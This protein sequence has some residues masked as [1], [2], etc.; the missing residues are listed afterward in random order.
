[1]AP[2]DKASG[3][4]EGVAIAAWPL[5]NVKAFATR[6]AVSVAIAPTS[7]TRL[8]RVGHDGIR[9]AWYPETRA[10]SPGPPT[11]TRVVPPVWGTG[12][13]LL[14]YAAVA[15]GIVLPSVRTSGSPVA[16]AASASLKLV[17]VA[18][19]TSEGCGLTVRAI[20]IAVWKRSAPASRTT[21]KP[22]ARTCRS[23][24]G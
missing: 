14:R 18:T 9:P 16:P 22:R 6:T 7:G 17:P 10:L 13:R 1:M 15:A 24:A 4:V 20:A 11:V 23:T 8:I 3:Q 5:P 21:R 2:P 19:I 12:F